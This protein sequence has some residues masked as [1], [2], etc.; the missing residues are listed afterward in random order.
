MG[1]VII[2]FNEIGQQIESN[3][4][5]FK[6]NIEIKKVKSRKGTQEYEF[7]GIINVETELQDIHKKFPYK[8]APQNSK[9][10]SSKFCHLYTLFSLKNLKYLDC[11]LKFW[12]NKIKEGII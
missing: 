2:F 7:I 11:Y 9:D 4:V 6:T 3:G 8:T 1:N 10:N 12:K 5:Y